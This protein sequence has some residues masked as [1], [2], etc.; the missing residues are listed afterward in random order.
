MLD[1]YSSA[2]GFK[3]Y[4][5][6]LPWVYLVGGKIISIKARSKILN[7]ISDRKPTKVVCNGMQNQYI[8]PRRVQRGME[9]RLKVIRINQQVHDKTVKN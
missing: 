1:Y 2:R 4:K 3:Q 6:R 8:G 5:S 7:Q 9:Q